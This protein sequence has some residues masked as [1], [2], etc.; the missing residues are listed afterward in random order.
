MFL[1]RRNFLKQ[2]LSASTLLPLSSSVPAFLNRTAYATDRQRD[3]DN[4]VLVVVQLAGG[5]DGL[6]TV[7]P[8]SDDHYAKNRTT[9]RLASQEVHK[10]DSELGF[11]PRMSAFKR[12]YQEGYLSIVQ[13]VGY[14]NPD[15]DHFGGMQNWHTAKPGISNAQTGWLGRALDLASPQDTSTVPAVFAGDIAL[16]FSLN[17]EKTIVPSVRSLNDYTIQ[18]WNDSKSG[19]THTKPIKNRAERTKE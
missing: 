12:L 3:K 9:L 5:N 10:I 17:A 7:V 19:Q 2:F 11:H 4:T 15:K 18:A 6:N 1:P 8:Y 16:P 14:P 13:G